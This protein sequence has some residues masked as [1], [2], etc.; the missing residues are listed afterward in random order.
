MNGNDSAHTRRVSPIKNET[1]HRPKHF[2]NFFPPPLSSVPPTLDQ[3]KLSH[4]D[5]QGRKTLL[6]GF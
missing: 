1:S 6:V 3:P 5:L 2:R 4:G